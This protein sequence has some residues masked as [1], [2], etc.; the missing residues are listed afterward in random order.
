[1]KLKK[2]K[3][4]FNHWEQIYAVDFLSFEYCP[5][6]DYRE[7]KWKNKLKSDYEIWNIGNG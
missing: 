4:S 3:V 5:S 7:M 1:M 2:I 6:M